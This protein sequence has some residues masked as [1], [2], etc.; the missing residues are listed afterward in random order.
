ME[1]M[2]VTDAQLVKLFISLGYILG[3]SSTFTVFQQ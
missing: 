3:G 1:M 2:S